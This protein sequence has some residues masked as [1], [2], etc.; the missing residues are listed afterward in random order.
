MDPCNKDVPTWIICDTDA[1]VD[2][3]VALCMLLASS[4]SLST[5]ARTKNRFWDE[6][7]I[8]T[9]GGNCSV[10]QVNINVAKIRRACG[11]DA[12]SVKIVSGSQSPST[13]VDGTY[14]HGK[15]GL[16]DVD[17]SIIPDIDIDSPDSPHR[18]EKAEAVEDAI[19]AF[20]EAAK[21]AQA[22]L[23]IIALGPCTNISK[24]YCRDFA[25]LGGDDV[26]YWIMGGCGD[27]RGNV[28]RVA[29]FNVYADP[30]SAKHIMCDVGMRHGTVRVIPWE[31]TL[32]CPMPN[33]LF[34][35]YFSASSDNP[36]SAFLAAICAKVYPAS[37]VEKHGAVICDALAVAAALQIYY[38][39]FAGALTSWRAR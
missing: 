5:A 34:K 14:Y 8:T 36:V 18:V 31:T 26:E 10:E 6:L 39:V 23:K 16:G 29:E 11:H 28:T 30:E 9:V 13:D 25:I 12:S 27:A 20:A 4:P 22:R 38:K 17:A 37:D 21:A 32:Q 1:G 15:D 3:A 2:D 24:A 19:L 35:H 7:L 33:S